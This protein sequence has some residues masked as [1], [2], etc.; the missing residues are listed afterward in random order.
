MRRSKHT[1]ACSILCI[2]LLLELGALNKQKYTLTDIKACVW[3]NHR[4]WVKATLSLPIKSHLQQSWGNLAHQRFP[5]FWWARFPHD[6]CKWDFIGRDRVAFTQLRW[7]PQMRLMF[8][9]SD[10]A[11]H[12][13]YCYCNC[14]CSWM[15]FPEHT[16]MLIKRFIIPNDGMSRTAITPISFPLP[17]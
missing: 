11:S 10:H 4:N 15:I 7:F 1:D 8:L 16:R 2:E 3:G 14:Y 13:S 17:I 12:H 5:K 6:C 9:V